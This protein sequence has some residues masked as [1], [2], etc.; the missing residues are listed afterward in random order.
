MGIISFF[1][2]RRFKKLSLNE[3]LSKLRENFQQKRSNLQK[4]EQL[5]VK[6]INILQEL[7]KI[8]NKK[9]EE[10]EQS[11]RSIPA[12]IQEQLSL[13]KIEIE[14]A[15]DEES[16]LEIKQAGMNREEFISKLK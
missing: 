4:F 7:K 13:I 10:A 14:H 6:K 11:V 5:Q 12:S 3:L 8:W 16:I 2:K 15:N 9:L 1:K